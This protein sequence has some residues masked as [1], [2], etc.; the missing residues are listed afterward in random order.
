[1]SAPQVRGQYLGR[2][3]RSLDTGANWVANDAVRKVGQGAEVRTGEALLENTKRGPSVINDLRI[4]I[5]GFKANIDHLVMHGNRILLIDAK[6]WAGGV[7]WTVGG[8]TRRGMTMFPEADKKTLPTAAG[9][10][11]R[12]LHKQGIGDFIVERPLLAVWNT[13]PVSFAAYR[14]AGDT[15]VVRGAMLSHWLKRH[16]KAQGAR[17]DIMVALAALAN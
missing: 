13:T 17:P 16:T 2:A 7:F 15:R 1:M 10:I 11:Q 5:P 12:F 14:P 4:P 3:G 9:A 8:V 6:A